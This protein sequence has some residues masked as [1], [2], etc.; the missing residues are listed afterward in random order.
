M[1]KIKLNVYGISYSYSASNAYALVL[2]EEDGERRIPIMIGA[3]EAQS[4]AIQMEGLKSARPLTHDLFYTFAKSF[5]IKVVKVVINRF[6][7]GIFY[8]QLVCKNG[9][10][11]IK[12]DS[13]TSDAVALA[14][15][16]NC[17]IYTT[18]KIIEMAGFILTA[19]NRMQAVPKTKP[20]TYDQMSVK[21]LEKA[22]KKAIETEN[23]E[24][25][26]VIRDEINKRDEK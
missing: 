12:I 6:E 20:K 24:K 16:F 11:T 19:D 2:A 3:S 7:K 10:E 25:A 9:T 13:R 1:K 14:L 18:S 8:S 17:P 22:L 23:Y 21:D 4:I 26:S 15:R 5:Q